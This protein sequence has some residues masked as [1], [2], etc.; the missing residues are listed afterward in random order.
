MRLYGIP[1]HAWNESFFKLCVLDC[2]RFLRS[3]SCSVD[4][5]R[6]DYARVLI[7]APSLDIV[8]CNESIFIDGE[9]V[10]VKIVE[11]WGFCIGDDACLYEESGNDDNDANFL[12]D[13]DD[14][15]A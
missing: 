1:L 10:E 3:D 15:D 5:D 12:G 14:N 4:R 9:M 11:E 8:N 6:F 13:K 2:G 7:A